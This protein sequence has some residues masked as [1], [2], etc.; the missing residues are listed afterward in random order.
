MVAVLPVWFLG[1]VSTADPVPAPWVGTESYGWVHRCLMMEY[2]DRHMT[3]VKCCTDAYGCRP[4]VSAECAHEAGRGWIPVRAVTYNSETKR[5]ERTPSPPG[6]A[7][8]PASYTPPP[9]SAVPPPPTGSSPDPIPAPWVGSDSYGWEHRCFDLNSRNN[10]MAHTT[11]V[12]CCTDAYGCRPMVSA[13]CAHEAGRGWIPVRAIVY[14]NETKRC[15]PVTSAQLDRARA[16]EGKREGMLPEAMQQLIS[17]MGSAVLLVFLCVL[18]VV[19]VW[20]KFFRKA[21]DDDG[22][23]DDSEERSRRRRRR[24]RRRRSNGSS[25]PA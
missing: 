9:P 11:Y 10:P 22:D 15:E 3:F 6:P 5:C 8:A 21:K 14:N 12:K 24:R 25:E 2:P 19:V 18:A 1:L 16:S 4:M 23:D 7:A 17:G 13:E 20:C